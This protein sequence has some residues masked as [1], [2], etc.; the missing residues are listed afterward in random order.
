MLCGKELDETV[1]TATLI[2]EASPQLQ[3]RLRLRS[4]ESGTDDKKV[5]LPIEGYVRSKKPWDAGG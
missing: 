3:E 2:E 1:K 4:E 5:I